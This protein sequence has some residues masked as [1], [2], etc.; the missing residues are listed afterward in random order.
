MLVKHTNEYASANEERISEA[1]PD[2]FLE[3]CVFDDLAS[4]S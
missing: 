1:L 2:G 4:Q 3:E